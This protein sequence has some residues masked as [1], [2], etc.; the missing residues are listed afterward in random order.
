M[1]WVDATAALAYVHGIIEENDIGPRMLE[2]ALGGPNA[3]TNRAI[4]AGAEGVCRRPGA[5]M[6]SLRRRLLRRRRRRRR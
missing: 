6:L 5:I 4:I 3:E 2:T 1:A